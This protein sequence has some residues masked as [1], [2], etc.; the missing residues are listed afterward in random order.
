MDSQ[1]VRERGTA[2]VALARALRQEMTPQQRLLW[3]AL[4]GN[5]L[6]GLHFRRQQIIRGYIVDFYCHRARLAIEIDGQIRERKYDY[7]AYRDSL[8]SK[9][10]IKVLRIPSKAID[11]S[12]QSVLWLIRE[13]TQRAVCT[14]QPI[15]PEDSLR[16]SS[17]P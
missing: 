7:D 9:E 13:H 17:N 5:A 16:A 6:D 2:T 14:T 4:R 3:Q 1:I 15:R 12:P 11:L 10:G 8:F